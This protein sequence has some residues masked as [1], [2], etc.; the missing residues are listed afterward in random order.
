MD[1]KGSSDE[2]TKDFV[3]KPN[4]EENELDELFD[5]TLTLEERISRNRT[6][7]RSQKTTKYFRGQTKMSSDVAS[8]FKPRN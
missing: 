3:F 7:T 1:K 6:F 2:E 4:L 5:D 8:L